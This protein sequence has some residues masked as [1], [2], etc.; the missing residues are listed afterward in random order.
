MSSGSDSAALVQIG[1]FLA[2]PR[3][4]CSSMHQLCAGLACPRRSSVLFSVLVSLCGLY[5]PTVIFC[6]FWRRD[7]GGFCVFPRRSLMCF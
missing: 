6:C 4:P 7:K 3:C 2:A 5:V 1:F